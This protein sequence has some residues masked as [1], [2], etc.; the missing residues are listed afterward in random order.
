MRRTKFALS[1]ISFFSEVTRRKRKWDSVQHLINSL[2]NLFPIPLPRVLVSIGSTLRADTIGTEIE[3]GSSVE[4]CISHILAIGTWDFQLVA[5]TGFLLRFPYPFHFTVPTTLYIGRHRHTLRRRQLK[6]W[7][8]VPIP[9]LYANERFSQGSFQSDLWF[10][11]FLV[12]T[13]DIQAP[14]PL[15]QFNSSTRFHANGMNGKGHCLITFGSE[16]CR[17]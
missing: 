8:K 5:K 10:F 4:K 15:I 9:T 11:D 3:L 2:A 12:P 6:W 13:G 14:K 1:L 16:R 7:C 17:E